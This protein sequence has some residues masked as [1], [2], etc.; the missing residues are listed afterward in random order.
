[1]LS[2]EFNP[3]DI[4]KYL[5]NY[6]YIKL[7]KG[8]IIMKIREGA[9]PTTLGAVVAITGAIVDGVQMKKNNYN[10]SDLITMAAAGVVGFGLAHIVLGGIDLIE[11]RRR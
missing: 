5:R 7:T 1:M 3:M 2:I 6:K 10:K 9:I 8:G 4:K 11:H